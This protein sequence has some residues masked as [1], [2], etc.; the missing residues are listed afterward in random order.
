MVQ[1]GVVRA[2]KYRGAVITATIRLTSHV[3][4]RSHRQFGF[5]S[6]PGSQVHLL[7][8][9]LVSSLSRYLVS[10]LLDGLRSP[11]RGAGV[12][13][14]GPRLLDD[15]GWFT[16]IRLRSTAHRGALLRHGVALFT[17][18]AQPLQIDE[19]CFLW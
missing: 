11:R 14:G 5:S 19:A 6:F 1:L 4:L 15:F 12:V 7:S 18:A 8:R 3:P 10:S 16:N 9:Y 2:G 17:M 13:W